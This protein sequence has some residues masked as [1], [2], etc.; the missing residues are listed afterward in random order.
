PLCG[1][2]LR[3]E[4]P[5]VPAGGAHVV[6]HRGGEIERR[7]PVGGAGLDDPSGLARPAELIAELRLVAVEGDQFVTTKGLE[8]VRGGRAG[9]RGPRCVVARDRGDLLVAPRVQ[10]AEQ[11]FQLRILKHAGILAKEGAPEGYSP[12]EG[13]ASSHSMKRAVCA[14][15]RSG[16]QHLSAAILPS[17]IPGCPR[18]RRVRRRRPGWS[19]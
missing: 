5:A 7:D 3:P 1:F 19:R 14:S 11:T 10:G 12:V 17:R 18:Q 15:L 13:W 16:R 2:V 4:P 6:A 9:L 8:L